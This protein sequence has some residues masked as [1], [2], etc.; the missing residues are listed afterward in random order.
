MTAKGME[1][2]VEDRVKAALVA[3]G[4]QTLD[5]DEAAKDVVWRTWLADDE[6]A[7]DEEDQDYPCVLIKSTPAENTDG[8]QGHFWDIPLEVTCMTHAAHD[9]KRST[10]A[11]LYADVREVIEY[12]TISGATVVSSI[13]LIIDSPGESGIDNDN[14]QFMRI[15][16]TAE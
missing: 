3:A 4:F 12:G 15:N 16:A 10:L 6:P 7:S 5:K 1:K 8:Y 11:T 13:N 9:P 2:D 14:L